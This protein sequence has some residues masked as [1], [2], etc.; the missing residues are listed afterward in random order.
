VRRATELAASGLALVPRVAMSRLVGRIAVLPLPS[1][2][3]NASVAGYCALLGVDLTEAEPSEQ[4]YRT[5]DA[6][7]TRRLRPGARPVSP[8]A[9]VSPAD[10]VLQA[11][12]VVDGGS[13]T[14]KGGPYLVGELTGDEED[15]ARCR[16]GAFAVVYLSPRDY[17]RVHA[18]V[19]GAV[20]CTTGIPGD[21]FPVNSLSERV[22]KLF[23]R[24][25][26]VAIR[27]ETRDFGRVT[28]VMVGAMNV[29]RIGI[30]V[31]GGAEATCGRVPLDP[32]RSLVRGDEVGV[33][34]LGSTVVV[35]TEKPASLLA[36][37][38][39]VRLGQSLLVAP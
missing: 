17:H 37:G 26:R 3:A 22:P 14:I 6:L 25:S 18:P 5:L 23:C 1:P 21:L 9:L 20:V 15:T 16:G 2:L 10:G 19:D 13:L 27:L 34:H 36:P 11:T 4:P 30:D 8:D 24:N 28:L 32:P 38:R 35:I 7:F 39:P 29:G 31:L 33:F 12:G